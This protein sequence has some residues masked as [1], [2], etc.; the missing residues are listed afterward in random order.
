M[1]KVISFTLVIVLF[2]IGNFHAS[3]QSCANIN[4]TE[5][6]P[7]TSLSP[8]STVSY[9]VYTISNSHATLPVNAATDSIHL[10][11]GISYV[12]F[13]SSGSTAGITTSSVSGTMDPVFSIP[14]IPA[15]GSVTISI[16]VQTP[17]EPDTMRPVITKTTF[18]TASIINCIDSVANTMTITTPSVSVTSVGLPILNLNTGDIQYLVYLITNP[19]AAGTIPNLNVAC[20]P[21]GSTTLLDYCIS[22]SSTSCTGPS[23]TIVAGNI[24]ITGTDI[25]TLLGNSYQGLAPGDSL[26]VRIRF[27]VMNCNPGPNGSYV[28]TWGCGPSPCETINTTTDINSLAPTTSNLVVTTISTIT[29]SSY[30]PGGVPIQMGFVYTNNGPTLTGSGAPPLGNAKIINMK[31]YI[32]STNA[33]GSINTSSFKINGN[34]TTMPFGSVV[35]LEGTFAAS[36]VW[37]ID[38]TQLSTALFAG[39]PAPFGPNSLRDIDGDGFIDDLREGGDNFTLTFDYSYATTCPAPFA[40]CGADKHIGV[41][42]QEKFQNQCSSL[43]DVHTIGYS[44][45]NSADAAYFY[46]TNST[47]SNMTAPPDV[48]ENDTFNLNICPRFGQLWGPNGYD[49]NCPNGYH[50]FKL[51]LPFGYHINTA[52]LTPATNGGNMSIPLYERC[53]GIFLTLTA[54]VTEFP[55]VG[56]TPGY[57]LINS[58]RI[59][60]NFCGPWN[61]TDNVLC[62]DVEL[63]FECQSDTA[64][65]ANFGVDNF[66]FMLEYICDPACVTCGDQ[67]TCASTSTYH[68]CLGTCAM[69]FSTDALSFSFKRTT[70]G[71]ENSATPLDPCTNPPVVV[72]NTSVINLEAA[73][74]GDEIEAKLKGGF[75]GNGADY[76]AMFMQIRYDQLLATEAMQPD[77]FI[78]DP[79]KASTVLITSVSLGLSI[80]DTVTYVF[81]NSTP[82]EMNFLLSP[83]NYPL[84]NAPD[85]KF[86][87]KIRLI[88]KS[89]PQFPGPSGTFYSYGKHK[90][91]GLRSEF[92]GVDTTLTFPNDTVKSCDSWGANFTM[93]QPEVQVFYYPDATFNQVTDCDPYQVSFIFRTRGA[94]WTSGGHDFPNEFRPYAALDTNVVITL[95]PGY[96]YTNT[97]MGVLETNYSTTGPNFFSMG[98]FTYAPLPITPTS[99]VVGLGGTTLTYNGRN[100]A[101][102]CWPLVDND[103]WYAVEPQYDITVYMK[104]TCDAPDTSGFTLVSGFTQSIQQP[105]TAYQF[106]RNVNYSANQFPV[107]H[108]NPVLNVT[109]TATV[110]AYSN[111]VDFTFTVC[112]TTSSDAP[113]GWATFQSPGGT[114]SFTGVTIPPSTTLLSAV[115]YGVGGILVNLGMIPGDSCVTFK[116]QAI[117]T[118]GGCV[119]GPNA[120]NDSI[121]VEWGNECTASSTS[122]SLETLCQQGSTYFNF[123]RYPSDLNLLTPSGFPS[124]AVNLCGDTLTYD[125]NITNPA[126]GTVTFPTFWMNL[127]PGIIFQSATFTY[128]YG[129]GTTVTSTTPSYTFG[130][131]LTD[132]GWNL[133]SLFSALATNGLTGALTSPNNQIQVQI[134][135]ITSCGYNPNDYL[136]FFAG[137]T[138]AC[139]Q[140]IVTPP[141]EHRPTI[142]NASLADSLTVNVSIDDSNINCTDSAT[143]TVTVTNNGPLS[144][145]NSNILSLVVPN[146]LTYSNVIPPATTTPVPGGTQLTWN[147]PSMGSG[148]TQ[149]FTF[150]VGLYNTAFC[151]PLSINAFTY[152]TDSVYCSSTNSSCIV[153]DSSQTFGV[154]FMACCSPCSLS[155]GADDSICYGGSTILT[156]TGGTTYTWMPGSLSGSSVTVSPTTTTSYTVS[157]VNSSG[158]TCYDTVT[159]FVNPQL[160]L[161]L[162][163]TTIACYGQN[164]DQATATVTGGTPG[165]T[166]VWSPIG[167]NNST[168]NGLPAGTYTVTVTDAA[169][170]TI[171]STITITQPPQLTIPIFSQTNVT[172]F[173]ANNGTASV[174][175]SGGTPG[176][177]YFWAPSGGSASAA[178]GLAP[179]SY[180][181]TV[182]DA[183]GCQATHIFNITQPP[184][185]VLGAS[186][187]NANCY[188]GTGSASVIVSG[189]TPGYTYSWSPFGGTGPNATGL[190]AGTYTCT[191]TD[192][193]GCTAQ[194]VFTITQPS[195]GMTLGAASN[196]VSCFGG[197]NGFASVIVMGGTPGYTYSWS[198]SGGT[199]SNATGLTAGTYTC[200]VTDANGCTAQQV[201]TITQPPLLAIV[202][203]AQTNVTC[204]GAG[205]GTA[206][207]IVSGGTPGY[208]YNWTPGNP[209]GDG[210][211]NVTGLIAGTWTCT[212]T[213]AN[214]CTTNH[215]F[216]ITRPPRLTFSGFAQNNVS[217]NGGSNGAASVVVSGGTPGYTYNWTPG[218]PPGDG[219]PSV[220]GLTA[221]TYTCTVT[222]ANGC[223]NFHVFTITQPPVLTLV[224]SS[225]TH[226]C[227]GSGGGATVVAGGGTPPYTYLWSP[228]SFTTPTISGV[229]PGP[230]TC[231]VTDANGCTK[232]VTFNI[233]NSAPVINGT[234]CKVVYKVPGNLNPCTTLSATVTGAFGP[235]SYSWSTSATTS[236]ITVCQSTTTS[237]TLTVTDAFGCVATAMYT[238]YVVDA[239]CGPF[240]NR[241]LVCTGGPAGTLCLPPSAASLYLAMNPAA[242]L[243]P[244]QENPCLTRSEEF[245]FEEESPTEIIEPGEDYFKAAPN[246]LNERTNLIFGFQYADNVVLKVY[247]L[248]GKEVSILFQG[249]VQELQSYTYEFNATDLPS[250]LYI[251]ELRSTL[252]GKVSRL[253]LLVQK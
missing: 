197:N 23:N 234:F 198:P 24:N 64:N 150:N 87:A 77:L 20:T 25:Q 160:T 125:F 171:T 157:S 109:T 178:V 49:F 134:K 161:T 218:N 121:L 58:T 53:T 120:V 253:K 166:Y 126:L 193:N 21:D 40:N 251:A 102:A 174:T 194:Q 74:P 182:T 67:L 115:P 3:A 106:H 183:N 55:P 191:V 246:P 136:N 155:A 76:S 158:A 100:L 187:T 227:F 237:Y 11:L 241:V 244:C 215:V 177:T 97:T 236:S 36:D 185:L 44:H 7:G 2:L 63:Y 31:L 252:S 15:G 45:T 214:G 199:G 232:S 135:V 83:A 119:S 154:M 213:D 114:L 129:V 92:G 89:S 14:T 90:L 248:T 32:M 8:C 123:L 149:T 239:R 221:G 19:S 34:P 163:A 143:V 59:P 54:S 16:T 128:P 245:A 164:A 202:G 203:A 71:Y 230:K 72:S 127:P 235:I 95:P 85:V 243:G 250:G 223:T 170:C 65:I 111:I 153:G 144:T 209:P 162:S 88:A 147:L 131:S 50:Q 240:L 38:L 172:C 4:V 30:C 220:N 211:S 224:V 139:S 140:S 189:G 27:K 207:V 99:V 96:Q 112:N 69:D 122:S 5:T 169:G 181:V 186:Q 61:E 57:V 98:N 17:C 167:G 210:T 62:F 138:S 101:A 51:D 18:N 73:Y 105:N 94:L 124:T 79:N 173:G 159:V 151:A 84:M 192:A 212:V 238:V 141:A 35:T 118:P 180:T 201:F 116:L 200:T 91:D 228:G 47:G 142:L 231:T 41:S 56:S 108:N 39:N 104:P 152:Y 145:A 156:A 66:N 242:Y 113:F 219:T 93:L 12:S 247:D 196:N 175:P 148:N 188:G 137:G 222:D 206:S 22:T 6:V 195:S 184:A 176:Y 216:T 46:A 130:P 146:P 78:Q 26:Y 205:N 70:L 225:V 86:D 226:A 43:T 117:V 28:F 52:A 10:P 1:K 107:Y 37:K 48:Q 179:G 133:N 75:S 132:P 13:N 168:A 249:A 60:T 208:T 110:N 80:L 165:Y 42:T 82:A 29:N 68:H 229:P 233:R 9:F 204:F 217:C 33:L 190:T 81:T 103:F